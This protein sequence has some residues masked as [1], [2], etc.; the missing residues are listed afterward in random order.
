VLELV[1][2][3]QRVLALDPGEVEFGIEK[4]RVLPLRIGAL[5]AECGKSA[6]DGCGWEA[7]GDGGIGGQTWDV[8]DI[9]ADRERILAG[10][11]SGE[12]DAGFEDFVGAEETGVSSGYLVVMDLGA[13]VGLAIEGQWNFRVN[14]ALVVAKSFEA[15]PPAETLPWSGSTEASWPK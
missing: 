7:S 15:T 14:G 3:L 1:A 9:V 11:R 12:A 4:R 8:E 2:E 10:L 13:A 5:T 6:G